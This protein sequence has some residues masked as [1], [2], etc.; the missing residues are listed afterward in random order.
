MSRFKPVLTVLLFL[1]GELIFCFEVKVLT[2][3]E[4]D[5]PFDGSAFDVSDVEFSVERVVGPVSEDDFCSKLRTGASLVLDTTITGRGALATL[6]G[7]SGVP[8]L[9]FASDDHKMG[10]CR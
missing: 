1:G 2:L 9:H 5:S 8:Y 3:A 6:A 7:R 10:K 4:N